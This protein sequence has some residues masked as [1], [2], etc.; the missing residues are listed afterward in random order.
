MRIHHWVILQM[1]NPLFSVSLGTELDG[2]GPT[3]FKLY[4]FKH[5]NWRKF[6]HK[7]DELYYDKND[8]YHGVIPTFGFVWMGKRINM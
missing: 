8:K 4:E 2:D 1:I 3:G 6:I 5:K 7:V